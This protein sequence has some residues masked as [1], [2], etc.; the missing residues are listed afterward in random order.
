[1][2]VVHGLMAVWDKN[3]V[4]VEVEND[5]METG[6]Q[7]FRALNIKKHYKR[8]NDEDY[9]KLSERCEI[10]RGKAIP[11]RKNSRI[12]YKYVDMH[13]DKNNMSDVEL[14]VQDV[15]K[16]HVPEMKQSYVT[17]QWNNPLVPFP[18]RF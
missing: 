12:Y 1:M 11:V 8:A 2:D 3:E 10:I 9:R 4:K 16:D 7:Y 5:I 13:V 14:P 6:F 18:R 15:Y 17:Q